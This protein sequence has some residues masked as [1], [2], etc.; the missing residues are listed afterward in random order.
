MIYREPAAS[1]PALTTDT[2]SPS[3]NLTNMFWIRKVDYCCLTNN[4]RVQRS[5]VL[6]FIQAIEPAAGCLPAS[7]A[8]THVNKH[9]NDHIVYKRPYRNE[10]TYISIQ[11]LPLG[12]SL[13][14][15]FSGCLSVSRI[16]CVRT[17]G[18]KVIERVIAGVL[19][20][21][22]VDTVQMLPVCR[23]CA[24]ARC[25]RRQPEPSERRTSLV[26]DYRE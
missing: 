18:A 5:F 13:S 8:S 2:S 16:L 1:Q 15:S 6:C 20:G 11:Q 21:S 4:K 23:G 26:I 10:C 3:K 14:V 25:T 19:G 17:V 9:P 7:P 22:A 24:A 12:L